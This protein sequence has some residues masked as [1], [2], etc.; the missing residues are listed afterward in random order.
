VIAI[1]FVLLEWWRST[2]VAP[3]TEPGHTAEAA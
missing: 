1:L 3:T 2:R